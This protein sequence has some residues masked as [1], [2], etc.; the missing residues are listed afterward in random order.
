ML[1]SSS[2]FS[3]CSKSLTTF[4]SSSYL[5][6]Y[7]YALIAPHFLSLN[8]PSI[9]FLVSVKRSLTGFKSAIFSAFT[10]I[11]LLHLE[12]LLKPLKSV[13]R[14]FCTLLVYPLP[15]VVAFHIFFSFWCWFLISKKCVRDYDPF[16]SA[17][18]L[19][20]T[21]NYPIIQLCNTTFIPSIDTAFIQKQLLDNQY[22]ITYKLFYIYRTNFNIFF[23]SCL[24]CITN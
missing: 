23:F 14:L 22:W 6:L 3:S 17:H 15:L 4:D 16:Y 24:Y 20:I 5:W 2:F 18:F 21:P 12:H 8:N 11:S 13:S 19:R 1:L 7:S 9:C 10:L